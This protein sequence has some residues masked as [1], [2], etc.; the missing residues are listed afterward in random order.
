MGV[1]RAAIAVIIG[2]IIGLLK[3]RRN[4]SKSNGTVQKDFQP[5]REAFE[6]VFFIFFSEPL[7]GS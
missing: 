3:I 2:L 5:I 7:K 6:L 1:R 4:D